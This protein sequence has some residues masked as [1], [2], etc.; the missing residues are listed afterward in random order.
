MVHMP[1]VYIT[2]RVTFNAAHRLHNPA[3]DDD[4]NRAVF[5]GCSNPNW[6]GHNYILEV[7]IAGEPNPDTGFVMNLSDLK[8]I[9]E[10]KILDKVDHRNLNVEVDFM[11]GIMPSTEN[12][13]VAVW[14]ELEE[15]VPPGTLHAVRIQE[16]ENNSA[17]YFGE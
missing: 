16:T 17:E 2:R 1:K 15:E 10:T 13:A 5:G 12:L 8:R 14:K 11:Q 4:Q 6:H 3:W 9:L 7:T